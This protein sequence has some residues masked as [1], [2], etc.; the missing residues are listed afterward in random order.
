[1]GVARGAVTAS[2]LAASTSSPLAQVPAA[3]VG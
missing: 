3:A 2:S 1:V